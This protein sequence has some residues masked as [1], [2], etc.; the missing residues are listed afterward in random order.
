MNDPSGKLNGAAWHLMNQNIMGPG[1]HYKAILILAELA[2]TLQ[3]EQ[4][5]R[6]QQ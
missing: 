1:P 2:A 6:A 4:L 5:R 3:W